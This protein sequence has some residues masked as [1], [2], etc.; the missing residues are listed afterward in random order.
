[1]SLSAARHL[2][3]TW[4]NPPG[5]RKVYRTC[6]IFAGI[7]YPER[8][9]ADLYAL[10]HR[11]VRGQL[12]V[13]PLP[14]KFG[15]MRPSALTCGRSPPQGPFLQKSGLP[16]SSVRHAPGSF[17]PYGLGLDAAAYV[18]SAW[19]AVRAFL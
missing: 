16:C 12:G 1:M 14:T 3:L 13:F 11:Y 5:Q 8:D 19:V 15:R 4:V 9:Q 10:P 6:Q 18:C 2:L 7:P 17:S